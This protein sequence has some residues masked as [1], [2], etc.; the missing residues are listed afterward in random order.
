MN[1]YQNKKVSFEDVPYMMADLLDQM[2]IL[3][4]RVKFIESNTECKTKPV[5]GRELLTTM[6]VAMMLKV[7]RITVYRMASRGDILCYRNGKNL[8]FYKDEITKW[9]ESNKTNGH[10]VS[11][12][13]V[14]EYMNSRINR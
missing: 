14:D 10:L 12:P 13:T 5:T 1:T 3:S 8:L 11:I 4:D 7:A 9:I 6:E 2:R